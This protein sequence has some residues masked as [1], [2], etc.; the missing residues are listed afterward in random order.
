ME[1]PIGAH[2]FSNTSEMGTVAKVHMLEECVRNAAVAASGDVD[3]GLL[4]CV[5]K[6]MRV[7]TSDGA[8]RDVGLVATF[9]EWHGFV[10]GSMRRLRR[11]CSSS[12]TQRNAKELFYVGALEVEPA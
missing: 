6:N 2:E 5:H 10:H 8:D 4:Q 7:W 12:R 3:G 9:S 1:R 11:G